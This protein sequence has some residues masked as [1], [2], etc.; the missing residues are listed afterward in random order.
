MLDIASHSIGF[1][2]EAATLKSESP[3]PDHA[4][5]YSCGCLPNVLVADPLTICQRNAKEL[6]AKLEAAEKALKEVESKTSAVEDLQAKLDAADEARKEA[7]ARALT[8]ENNLFDKMKEIT[9]REAGIKKRLDELTTSFGS[10][11][12]FSSPCYFASFTCLVS[13]IIFFFFCLQQKNF[14]RNLH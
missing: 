7:E 2:N 5:F 4:N 8:A 12:E 14:G 9:S 11:S 13:C 6:E 1:R 3:A 10:K